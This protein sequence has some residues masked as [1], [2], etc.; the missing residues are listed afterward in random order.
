[1][2][3]LTGSNWG[4]KDL[5]PE[6]DGPQGSGGAGNRTPVRASIRNRFYVRR[7]RFRSPPA[8]AQPP[9]L[10]TI[11]LNLTCRAEATRH[12]SPTLRYSGAASGGLPPEQVREAEAYAAI[13]R[14]ELAV[15]SSQHFL[16]G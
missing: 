9:N 6:P 2:G 1:M 8:G 10:R 4:A 7:P 16:P 15:E 13:A 5:R 12:A 3:H 14:L 11:F